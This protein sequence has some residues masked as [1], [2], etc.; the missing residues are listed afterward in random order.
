MLA[1]SPLS[2]SSA[3]QCD[4]SSCTRRSTVSTPL[5]NRRRRKLPVLMAR[6]GGRR[7]G[8]GPVHQALGL[9]APD[10]LA[11]VAVLEQHPAGAVD[12]LRVGAHAVARHPAVG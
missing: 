5:P 4:I 11:V 1:Y 12:R 7:G 10:P 9:F 2:A 3:W 6:S 8:L